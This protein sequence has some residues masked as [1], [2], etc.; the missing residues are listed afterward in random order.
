MASD[1]AKMKREDRC[2]GAGGLVASHNTPHTTD[3][4]EPKNE[5]PLLGPIDCTCGGKRFNPI[6]EGDIC[7]GG[8]I[9]MAFDHFCLD[10]NGMV[11]SGRDSTKEG[12]AD[13]D[14]K[15]KRKVWPQFRKC[16]CGQD[17]FTP[18]NKTKCVD[19]KVTTVQD[20]TPYSDKK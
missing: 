2:K 15:S 14:V 13:A 6:H 3:A 12:V 16:M 18:T 9:L 11:V 8:Q 10:S 19:S 17:E 4:P 1:F 5:M 20:N 7:R